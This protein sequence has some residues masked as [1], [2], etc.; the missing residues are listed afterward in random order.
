MNG[1]K[2]GQDTSIVEAFTDTVYSKS[3]IL[4]NTDAQ[5]DEILKAVVPAVPHFDLVPQPPGWAD[6]IIKGIGKGSGTRM[7]MEQLGVNP[8]EALVFGDAENDLTMPQAV[9]RSVAVANAIFHSESPY[10]LSYRACRGR[11]GGKGLP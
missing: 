2:V 8:D 4:L 10:P 7:L 11:C 1:Q 9:G 6:V 5:R 3:G